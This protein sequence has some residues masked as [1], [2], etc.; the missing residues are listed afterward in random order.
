MNNKEKIQS[1]IIDAEEYLDKNYTSDNSEFKA[2]NADLIRT[3]ERIYG[4]D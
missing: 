2:W 3:I 1:L 4:K